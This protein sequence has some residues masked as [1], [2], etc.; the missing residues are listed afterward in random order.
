MRLLFYRML[1][2]AVIDENEFFEMFLCQGFKVHR[3]EARERIASLI[4]HG[5]IHIKDGNVFFTSK[6]FWYTET[7]EHIV[8]AIMYGIILKNEKMSREEFTMHY[9]RIAS[10]LTRQPVVD[11][12]RLILQRLRQGGGID[13]TNKR[14]WMVRK[15]KGGR[16]V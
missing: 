14:V 16:N 3:S 12:S 9:A 4:L 6:G 15:R 10:R 13:Y 8:S 5:F 7:Y 11:K 2:N 1:D